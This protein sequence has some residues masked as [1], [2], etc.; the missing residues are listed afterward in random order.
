MFYNLGAVIELS[1]VTDNECDLCWL[2]CKQQNRMMLFSLNWSRLSLPLSLSSSCLC[3]LFIPGGENHHDF[4]SGHEA[5][6][7]LHHTQ[8]HRRDFVAGC[9]RHLRFL[10][11]LLLLHPSAVHLLALVILRRRLALLH[12]AHTHTYVGDLA[13]HSR[14]NL[15]FTCDH[16]RDC[17][18]LCFWNISWVC[19]NNCF[20]L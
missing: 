20:A 18:I 17:Y 11:H 5:A 9:H 13:H 3:F 7:A 8:Q 4:T 6:P 10:L 19:K 1:D 14:D 16:I 15:T 2:G 12:T